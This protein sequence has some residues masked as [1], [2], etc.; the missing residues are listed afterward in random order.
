MK[1]FDCFLF[2]NEIELL[3]LRFMELCDVVDYFVIAEANKTH[4]GNHKEFIFEQNKDRYKPYLDKVIYVKIEDC[5]KADGWSIEKFQR[6]ALQRG[7][8]GL[9]IQGDKILLSDVDEIPN[10]ET[11]K[12]NLNNSEWL[13]C[14][15]SLFYYYV[16]CQ[17]NKSCGGT[18]IASYETFNNIQ[19]LRK[20]ARSKYGMS[21][22]KHSNVLADSGWHYSY[23]LGND[24][25]RIKYKVKNI[26]ESAD[27]A[28]LAGNEN[29]IAN[30]VIQKK[31]L[32]NR[33]HITM[34]IVDINNT[35]PKSMNK[36][37][38]KYPQFFYKG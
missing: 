35:Q 30:K 18:T 16:N 13:Y 7:L 26:V 36:F 20:F 29:E 4:V 33:E 19:D 1:I 15:Q 2:F 21:P 14:K 25:N 11:I 37:L 32:Y 10:P 5:P 6:A 34:Q 23:L 28:R 9:A 27:L 22:L 31:D 12:N 38:E 17:V 3:E 24:P 8:N